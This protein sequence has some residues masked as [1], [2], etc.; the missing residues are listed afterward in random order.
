MH[1][2]VPIRI[3]LRCSHR[4]HAKIACPVASFFCLFFF[5]RLHSASKSA[6]TAFCL[7]QPNS[8]MQSW[9]SPAPIFCWDPGKKELLMPICRFGGSATN[10]QTF[11]LGDN[12]CVQDP[13]SVSA[14]LIS[15]KTFFFCASDLR[16][17][18]K[19]IDNWLMHTNCE[20]E[21]K[22]SL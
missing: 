15:S 18:S 16:D 21:D 2:W 9:N 4:N 14:S 8:I 13:P 3:T 12:H 5:Q 11:L 10:K 6:K 1:L 17:Q 19:H 20:T 7:M 22:L